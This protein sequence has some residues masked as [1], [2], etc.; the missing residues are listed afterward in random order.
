MKLITQEKINSLLQAI[1]QTNISAQ[2]FDAIKKMLI[3][4]PEEKLEKNEPKQK[5]NK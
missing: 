1:Y 5:D 4:L 2:V 3:E